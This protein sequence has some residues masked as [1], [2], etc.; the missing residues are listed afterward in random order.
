MSWYLRAFLQGFLF[1]A[2]YF[3]NVAVSQKGN[4]HLVTEDFAI[5]LSK[6]WDISATPTNQIAGLAFI[7]KKNPNLGRLLVYKEAGEKSF[8]NGKKL[9]RRMMD[10]YG[11]SGSSTF[12]IRK[13]GSLKV[14][15]RDAGY[16]E[17]SNQVG[18]DRFYALTIS[19]KLNTTNYF[20]TFQAPR[21]EYVQFRNKVIKSVQRLQP[22]GSSNQASKIRKNKKSQRR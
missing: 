6:V 7:D 14:R 16:V 15:N 17:Y 12:K 3:P 19:F 18:P 1:S 22:M 20:V 9:A 11:F 13:A 4:Q 2:F 5:T 21:E 10:E 8:T